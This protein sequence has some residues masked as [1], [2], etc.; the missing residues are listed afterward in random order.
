METETDNERE[1]EEQTDQDGQPKRMREFRRK[2]IVEWGV[3]CPRCGKIIWGRTFPHRDYNLKSHMDKHIR[4]DHLSLL[5][6]KKRELRELEK[7]RKMQ[8]KI[9]GQI[10]E[11]VRNINIQKEEYQQ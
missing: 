11:V 8:D 9:R 6:K 4:N 7:K 3:Q 10:Q 2:T 1:V 5:K